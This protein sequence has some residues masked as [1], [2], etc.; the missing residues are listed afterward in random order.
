MAKTVY[1]LGELNVDMIAG[2]RDVTPEWNKEKLL[3]RFNLVLGS[4]SAITAV[5]LA[6]LGLDVR[7]VSIVGDDALGRFCVDALTAMNVDTSRVVFDPSRATGVTL[8][9]SGEKDRA[10]LTY[11]GTIPLL[12]PEHLPEELYEQADHIHFGSYYLQDGMREHWKDVFGKAR[13]QGCSTSFD[14][15]WDIREEWLPESISELLPFTT[16]FIPSRDELTAIYGVGDEH[17]A[18]QK[19]PAENGTVAV[20]RG[21]AGALIRT[22]DGLLLERPAYR[23]TP[24]DTT[25]AGDSFN[26]GLIY[27]HL[28]GLSP[29]E[30]L[31][32]AS[33]C[34]AMATLRIG[35]A[36]KAPAVE[37]VRS[38]MEEHTFAE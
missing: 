10:L 27:A 6:G 19:L 38:F 17:E 22:K 5:V 7:F 34:G 8:S 4:S 11:L 28:Q 36:S 13:Q 2:G 15:G 14:T 37:E 32:F 3:E 33:A 35:G 21:S 20:K 26:A 18:L 31:D 12:Q 29:A 9:L 23:I 24:I 30:S 16:L 1:V 25:G